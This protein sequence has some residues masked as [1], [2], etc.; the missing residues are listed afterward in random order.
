MDEIIEDYCAFTEASEFYG[1]N[2]MHV[3]YIEYKYGIKIN[4]YRGE[5]DYKD[6]TLLKH[7]INKSSNITGLRG[8][9]VVYKSRLKYKKTIS[10]DL[11]YH[12]EHFCTITNIKS[13]ARKFICEIYLMV[14]TRKDNLAR[15]RGK[16]LVKCP[17]VSFKACLIESQKF[18]V[19]K[20]MENFHITKE[21][22]GLPAEDK[23]LHEYVFADSLFELA[24]VK[25]ER[26]YAKNCYSVRL[27]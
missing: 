23:E 25:R 22:L 9:S 3:V 24:K 21:Q 11:L 19:E 13:F 10:L 12:N 20:L 14:L 15:H 18:M 1:F 26:E 8:V 16:C 7:R 2:L 5:F 17:K 4:I 27:D 6:P